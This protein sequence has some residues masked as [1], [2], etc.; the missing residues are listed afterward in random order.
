MFWK[1]FGVMWSNL[2]H[3]CQPAVNSDLN[4]RH[5]EIKIK[6]WSYGSKRGWMT[7]SV[8]LICDFSWFPWCLG[9]NMK[10][11]LVINVNRTTPQ[12]NDC[13]VM[14]FLIVHRINH[15]IRC[16]KNVFPYGRVC[17]GSRYVPRWCPPSS[18]SVGCSVSRIRWANLLAHARVDPSWLSKIPG[19]MC[20]W[21][22]MHGHVKG[23]YGA[24]RIKL[25][26]RYAM[27]HI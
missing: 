9:R 2:E 21:H 14:F 13:F 4:H 24:Y 25:V 8:M 23:L 19:P 17:A 15:G 1:S 20:S 11:Q 22:F 5:A 12:S 6:P 18:K 7:K 27:I 26:Y 16:S 3:G 10:T